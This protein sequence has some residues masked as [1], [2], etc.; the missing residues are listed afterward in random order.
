MAAFDSS[1]AD[2]SGL[3]DPAELGGDTLAGR[4]FVHV[5]VLDA[6]V[7]VDVTEREPALGQ[8]GDG[9]SL[10]FRQSI[11]Q[12]ADLVR[13]VFIGAQR[14]VEVLG[15]VGQ[16]QGRERVLAVGE[17]DVHAVRFA[18]EDVGIAARHRSRSARRVGFG[19]RIGEPEALGADGREEVRFERRH[20]V[21][22]LVNHEVHDQVEERLG[23]L[24]ER[25][26]RL[27]QRGRFALVRDLRDGVGDVVARV[28]VDAVIG[29]RA[30][31]VRLLSD[32]E[33]HADRASGE[34]RL[35]SKLFHSKYLSFTPTLASRWNTALG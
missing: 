10:S 22:D 3:D 28:A 18:D 33:N 31:H 25:F 5:H 2:R 9:G 21:A 27:P 16:P 15:L 32:S 6:L 24:A 11:Q 29:G 8:L 30:G 19:H 35:L 26:D 12:G 17:S 23:Q 7:D 34:A 1:A 4:A 20:V 13:A 14:V